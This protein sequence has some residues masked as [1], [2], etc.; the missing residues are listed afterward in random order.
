MEHKREVASLPC[1]PRRIH[2]LGVA[3]EQQASRGERSCKKGDW[4][5]SGAQ[6]EW[7]RML[8]SPQEAEGLRRQ[9][10][11]WVGQSCPS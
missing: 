4:R 8:G 1:D 11:S 3:F 9:G 2:E 7:N 10:A 5:A 6:G